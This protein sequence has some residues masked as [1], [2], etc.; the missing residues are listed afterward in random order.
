MLGHLG[1]EL[2]LPHGILTMAGGGRPVIPHSYCD[3][4]TCC[5][6]LVAVFNHEVLVKQPG[7]KVVPLWDDTV[8]SGSFI[9]Y[10]TTL[11]SLLLVISGIQYL[12]KND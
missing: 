10:V 4:D 9:H 11:T 8:V 2:R 12:I 7:H 1:W 5:Y 3:R 6:H